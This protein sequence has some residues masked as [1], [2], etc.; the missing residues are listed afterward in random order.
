[1]ALMTKTSPYYIPLFISVV[2]LVLFAIEISGIGF[3]AGNV[4]AYRY[5]GVSQYELWRLFSGNFLHTNFW[6]LLMNLGGLWVIIFLH[7]MH[8][9][10]HP[11]KLILLI[12][13][14]SLIQGVGLYYLFPETKGFVGL[15]GMLH[16]LFAFGAIMDV[17]KG[18]RSGYMLLI[19]VIVK[20]MYE[21]YF[22]APEDMST[23]IGARV[24]IESHF[25]GLFS[26]VIIGLFWLTQANR[27]KYKPVKK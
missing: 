13:V 9:K 10:H 3:D 17:R 23:L 14:L 21:Q 27:F 25:I 4:L 8:Y 15:S 2:C 22:G 20:V 24:S 26:G 1:M 5:D 12:S 6:H 19:G 18:F 16:G 7:E 11:G